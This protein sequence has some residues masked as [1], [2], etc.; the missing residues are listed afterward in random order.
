MAFFLSAL[1]VHFRDIRDLLANVVQFW[2]F[3]TPIIYPYFAATIRPY[4]GY[5]R[6]N[7]MY[8]LIVSYQEALF[9]QGAF[10]HQASLLYLGGASLL[11]LLCGYW[12]FDRLRDSFAEAV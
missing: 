3:A 1:T 10:G 2:F 8:H 6:L 12:L 4:L 7:P 5:F 11:F 9:F